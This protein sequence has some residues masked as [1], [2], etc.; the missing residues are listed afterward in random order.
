MDSRSTSDQFPGFNSVFWLGEPLTSQHFRAT[1]EIDADPTA[2]TRNEIQPPGAIESRW[3]MGRRLP[4]DLIWTDDATPLLL[5]ARVV[6]L[7][8]QH[9]LTGWSTYEIDLF[10]KN[11]EPIP[12]YHGLSVTGRCG[13]ID[14]SMSKKVPKQF[15]AKVSTVWQGLYFDPSTWDG[16]SIFMPEGGWGYILITE[17]VK[18]ALETAKVK[19]VAFTCLEEVERSML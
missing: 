4:A 9:E 10:G 14:N 5:S 3:V 2:L 17:A 18:R 7:F 13:P 6:S 16:S 11:G 15:P 8:R 19:N 12:G 1:L